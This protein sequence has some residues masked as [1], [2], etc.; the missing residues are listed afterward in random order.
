MVVYCL[1]FVLRGESPRD[2]ADLLRSLKYPPSIS[3]SDIPDRLAS[4]VNN[5]VPRFFTPNNGRLFPVTKD[6]LAAAEQ[7]ILEKRL[8]WIHNEGAPSLAYPDNECKKEEFLH[9]ITQVAD[10]Y[11]LSDRFHERNGL[12]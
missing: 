12:F 10:R 9:P 8:P 2:Y 7:G 11:S 5:S 6:N 3:I 1:K 4:H